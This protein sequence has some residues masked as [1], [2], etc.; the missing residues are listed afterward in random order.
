[1]YNYLLVRYGEI[2]LKG[3]NRSQF[4]NLLIRNMEETLK[5]IDTKKIEK[6]QGRLFVPLNGK[7]DQLKEVSDRITKVFGIV[8]VSPAMK[9]K[10]DLEIIRETALQV[11]KN[12]LKDRTV[13]F[14][15]DC[16][17]A[18]K[19]FPKNSMELSKE[20]GAH[21]LKNVNGLKVDVKKPELTLF[22]EVREGGT[23]VFCEKLEGPGG[24]PV[25]STGKGISLLSGG[26]DSPVASW[27]AMKRGIEVVGLHF[28]SYPFTSERSLKKVEEL[29]QV[30]S[31]YGGRMKLYVNHFTEIQK[32][33]QE[34]CEE[35]MRITVM[36]RFMFR[37]ANKMAEKE[38][39]LTLITGENV[40]Q[41]A[42]QTLES[43]YVV[44]QGVN[45]PILRPLAGMD[46]KEIMKLAE[47]IGTYDISI[48]PYDDCCT[49][50]LPKNP[51]TRPR[52]L[53]TE[54][55]ESKLPVD[56]LIEESIQKTEI[57]YLEPYQDESDDE[58]SLDI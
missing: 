53:H 30:V 39:A 2:G 36:R 34:K 38:G 40:G 10:S 52:L 22:V 5:N 25:S 23:F 17:R 28:H 29:A 46:K 16:R 57:K 7:E 6:S 3:K 12:A 33:I 49:L 50:F 37:I 35:S 55:E 24:L 9:V 18:D 15:V 19:T 58:L 14:K 43:M 32:A 56:E 54:R 44:S 41:V 4:E 21:I 1:M 31:N 13:T 20:L 48:R 45:L 26:I 51:K 27:L 47:Q 8:S 42:S 11:V